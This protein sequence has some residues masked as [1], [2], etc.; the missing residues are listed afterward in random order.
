VPDKLVRVANA[1][2]MDWRML[3]KEIL[4]GFLIAGFIAAI[5][6]A[7]WWKDL[8]IQ[9]GPQ[10][11]R[12]VENAMIGPIIAMASFVCSVGNIPLASLLWSNG[13]SF[14][15]VISFIYGDLIVIPLILIYRKYY[16]TRA[17][18]YL[19]IILYVSMVI[20]GIIVD[21][22]FAGAGLIPTGPRVESVMNHAMIRWN[23]T[24]WLDALAGVIAAIL[25]WSY[26][27][28]SRANS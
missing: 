27:R 6:P 23:Y 10:W 14:G 2:V 19:T 22:A 24:T 16:G 4:G 28:A 8:F 3:W 15:G 1:F 12:L 5:V 7:E 11:L 20:A 17:A 21:L 9:G 25:F 18:I 13:I 26:L